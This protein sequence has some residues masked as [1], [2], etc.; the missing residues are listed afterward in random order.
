[1]A[2]Y[3]INIESTVIEV[4]EIFLKLVNRGLMAETKAI[5]LIKKFEQEK[6][7]AADG[8]RVITVISN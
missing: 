6:R 2:I 4:R 8:Q 7:N 3:N 5:E 1:M